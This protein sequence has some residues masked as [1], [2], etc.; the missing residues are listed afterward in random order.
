MASS[1][2]TGADLGPYTGLPSG[3]NRYFRIVL[4]SITGQLD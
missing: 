2:L 4:R 1:L 3:F